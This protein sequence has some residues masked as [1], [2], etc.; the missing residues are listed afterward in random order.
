MLKEPDNHVFYFIDPWGRYTTHSEAATFTSELPKLLAKAQPGKVFIVTSPQGVFSDAVGDNTSAF[1]P[2][3]E[4]LAGDDYDQDAYRALYERDIEN[5]PP[6]FRKVGRRWQ[7]EALKHIMTPLAVGTFCNA[8]LKRLSAK[9]R[10]DANTVKQMADNSNVEH[11]SRV[12]RDTFKNSDQSDIMSVVAIWAHLAVSQLKIT[13]EDAKSL[14]NLLRTGGLAT[15]PDVERIFNQLVDA[16]WLKPCASESIAHATVLQALAQFEELTPG[17]FDDTIDALFRGWLIAGKQNSILACVKAAKG[18]FRI[19]PAG[20]Q[21]SIDE[22]LIDIAKQAE[23]HN[24]VFALNEIVQYSSTQHPIAVLARLL[25]KV[26]PSPP[27][28]GWFIEMNPPKWMKPSLAASEIDQLKMD[29]AWFVEKFVTEYLLHETRSFHCT[30]YDPQELIDFLNQFG[31]PIRGWFNTA[32]ENSLRWSEGSAGFLTDCLCLID[33]PSLDRTFDICLHSYQEAYQDAYDNPRTFDNEECRKEKQGEIDAFRCDY[34]EPDDSAISIA[35]LALATALR[36]RIKRDGYTWIS[37]HLAAKYLLKP[38]SDLLR[39]KEELDELSDFISCCV[40]NGAIDDIYDVLRYGTD[41]TLVPIV[42]ELILKQT[43]LSYGA[44]NVAETYANLPQ[45]LTTIETEAKKV[46][47]EQRTLVGLRLMSSHIGT[48]DV[49]LSHLL[50]D[51]EQ[52]IVRACYSAKVKGDQ[53]TPEGQTARALLIYLV[54]KWPVDTAVYALEVLKRMGTDI[55]QWIERFTSSKDSETRA[56]A[57]RLCADKARLLSQGLVYE[58]CS[59]RVASLENLADHATHEEQLHLMTLVTDKSAYVRKAL[60]EC[61]GS[62]QWADGVPPLISLLRDCREFGTQEHDGDFRIFD[63]ARSACNALNKFPQLPETVLLSV[64]SFL[65]ECTASSVDTTVHGLLFRLLAKYPS[66]ESMRF[67]SRYI[68]ETWL[69]SKWSENNGRDLPVQCLHSIIEMLLSTPALAAHLDVTDIA[70]IAAWDADNDNLVGAALTVM[71]VTAEHHEQNI[72]P[73]AKKDSFTPDRARLLLA[74]SEFLQKTRPVQ[75][76]QH[77]ASDEPFMKLLDWATTMNRQPPYAEFCTANPS[78]ATWAD[79]LKDKKKG[80]P[81]Y[82]RWSIGRL[83]DPNSTPT[84]SLTYV[85]PHPFSFRE[86]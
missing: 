49:I 24:F 30:V 1:D 50:P 76:T 35:Q 18:R 80:V 60:A 59:C 40:Q 86:C 2:F 46:P 83:I 11:T 33:V 15:P 29:S 14:R 79:T 82:E 3:V 21:A 34:Y 8:L 43:D 61:I 45:F 51:V 17:W 37:S 19:V 5:W 68:S 52:R 4:H 63:V 47:I 10:I 69:K 64:R 27:R 41:S 71:G 26:E 22:H 72:A 32:F 78:V 44:N 23:A 6:A 42:V 38:W 73:L 67:C 48:I 74:V 70:Q 13:A 57:W 36:N 55:S 9:D 77:L 75:I 81:A 16:G 12:I 66:E 31:W 65:G 54:C 56:R 53:D 20:I 28:K 58:D 39:G 85:L 62:K 7:D 25:T 84:T